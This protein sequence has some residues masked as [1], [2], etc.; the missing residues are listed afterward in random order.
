MS[1]YVAV[2]VNVP[3]APTWRSPT[4]AEI[5]ANPAT[6]MNSLFDLIARTGLTVEN[7][8]TSP[9]VQSFMQK[10]NIKVAEVKIEERKRKT[11]SKALLWGGIAA[12][13]VILLVVRKKK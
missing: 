11:K 12:G 6:L 10:V 9:E 5:D 1:H 7:A 3:D 8:V 13:V 2:G 4:Q